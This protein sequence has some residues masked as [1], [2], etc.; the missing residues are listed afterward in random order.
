M[1]ITYASILPILWFLVDDF[2]YKGIGALSLTLV[3]VIIL[4]FAVF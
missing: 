4:T 2:T 1:S 3:D